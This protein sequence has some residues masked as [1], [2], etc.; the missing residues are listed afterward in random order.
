MDKP[1]T[2]LQGRIRE[3]GTSYRECADYLKISLATFNSKI[4][5]KKRSDGT[6][7]CFNIY[8]A[9]ALCKKL[10]IPLVD[11]AIFFTHTV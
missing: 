2:K 7:N 11:M 5:G 1:L 3:C 9:V 8:Q 10:E 4:N 6:Y